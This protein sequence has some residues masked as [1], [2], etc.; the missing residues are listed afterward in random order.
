MVT[1]RAPSE[2]CTWTGGAALTDRFSP[3]ARSPLKTTSPAPSLT[4]TWVPPAA[5]SSR[6][7]TAG[8][9]LVCDDGEPFRIGL[10]VSS[11]GLSMIS[12]AIDQ[13]S[14]SAITAAI[15]TDQFGPP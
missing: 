9:S 1:S 12:R 5:A 3:Y 6:I 4:T 2:D 11:T 10:L 13:I 14:T 8:P 15:S 7:G